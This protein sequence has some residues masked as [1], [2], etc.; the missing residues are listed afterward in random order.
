LGIEGILSK[1]ERDELLKIKIDK[2]FDRR[3]RIDVN[4]SAI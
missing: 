3:D 2:R 1:D 4:I